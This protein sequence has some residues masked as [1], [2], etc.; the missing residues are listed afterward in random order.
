MI[1]V[2][3]RLTLEP[4]GPRRQRGTGQGPA[5]TEH[6]EGAE[7]QQQVQGS[8]QRRGPVWSGSS[9]QAR[10]SWQA[11]GQ[12]WNESSGMPEKCQWVE[13]GRVFQVEGRAG[14][15]A[16]GWAENWLCLVPGRLGGKHMEL[17]VGGGSV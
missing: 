12:G 17:V 2:L 4:S 13:A 11:R 9:S 14:A 6:R 16:L 1:L 10:V 3:A 8:G 15:K 5:L 7:D